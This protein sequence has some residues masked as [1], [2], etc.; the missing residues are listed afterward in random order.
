MTSVKYE[1]DAKNLTGTLVGSK[2]LLTENL[3]NGALVTPT[4]D[5]YNLISAHPDLD[6]NRSGTSTLKLEI[7]SQSR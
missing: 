4:P 7:R 3:T 5:C 1:F 6:I 2:I